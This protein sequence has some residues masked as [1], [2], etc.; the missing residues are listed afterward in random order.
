M[1]ELGTQLGLPPD[2]LAKIP[3]DAGMITVMESDQLSAAQTAVQTLKILSV[4]LLVIVLGM[5]AV[6][7]YL[8]RGIRRE[9]LRNIGW[10]FALVGLLVVVIRHVAGNYA[11][12]ALT[13]DPYKAPAHNVFLIA[14]S[15]L[16]EIGWSVFFYG[17]VALLG[18]VLA[19]PTIY[20]IKARRFIAPTLGERQG[21]VWLGAGIVYILLVLWGPTHALRT[22]WGVLLLAA[23]GALGLWAFRRETLREFPV[24]D[25][26]VTPAT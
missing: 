20:A 24:S 23:L 8:A 22:L 19:G 26:A 7:L 21:I 6:A 3:P 11:V 1:T 4:W 14:S 10:A 12:N 16:G 15:T 2:A 5:Y 9:T 25:T 18:A 17:V 13:A